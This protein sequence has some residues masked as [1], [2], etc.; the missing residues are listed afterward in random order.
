MGKVSTMDTSATDSI[1]S[2][3][4][5]GYTKAQETVNQ[6]VISFLFEQMQE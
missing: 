5:A 3:I 1:Y 4:Q 6:M 2:D